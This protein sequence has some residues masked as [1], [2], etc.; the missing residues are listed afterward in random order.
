MTDD[1]GGG[2][3]IPRIPFF[4]GS[5]SVAL[6]S[7]LDR[8]NPPGPPDWVPPSTRFGYLEVDTTYLLHKAVFVNRWFPIHVQPSRP[9]QYTGVPMVSV[10]FVNIMRIC[11]HVADGVT[12]HQPSSPTH[13]VRWSSHRVV[14]LRD[15]SSPCSSADPRLMSRLWFPPSPLP[16]FPTSTQDN[17]EDSSYQGVTTRLGW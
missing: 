12:S 17:Q 15:H 11:V 6:Y 10:R 3:S 13:S 4:E 1:T 2:N 16:S 9:S 14:R 5:N 8:Q 7:Y